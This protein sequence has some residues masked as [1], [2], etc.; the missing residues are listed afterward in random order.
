MA[1]SVTTGPGPMVAYGGYHVLTKKALSEGV[2]Q[3]AFC[4]WRDVIALL[5]LAP[6]AFFSENVFG[7]QLLFLIGLGRVGP[8]TAAALQPSI[9]VLTFIIAVLT[10]MEVLHW[11]KADGAAKVAGVAVCT[12]G[13]LL[14]VCFRGPALVGS[15][16]ALLEPPP[17]ASQVAALQRAAGLD[18]HSGG[19]DGG[20]LSTALSAGGLEDWHVG[21]VC[22][23]GNC[24]CMAVYLTLQAPLLAR[25]PA[26]VSVTAFAYLF[27]AALMVLVGVLLVP[28]ASH[29]WLSRAQLLTVL[30][31][32]LVASAMNYALM[33]WVN[34]RVGPALVALYMPLQPLASALLSRVFLGST[35]FLG[36]VLGGLAILAGLYLVSWGRAEALRHSGGPLYK[37]LTES[38]VEEG[39]DAHGRP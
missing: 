38:Q 12:A 30:Y 37:R 9:P 29:W 10:G 26:P 27:G 20:W 36:S 16:A 4:V 14:L 32:G 2:N 15:G 39:S 34:K 11:R 8:P 5:V 1:G 21:V 18:A 22:L 25:Y 7:N 24:T 28:S 23:L 13:A 6:A 33:T 19:E 31:A 17:A 35:I 3:L